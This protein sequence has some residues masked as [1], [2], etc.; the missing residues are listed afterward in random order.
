MMCGLFVT[1][2]R[3]SLPLT[4]RGARAAFE[5]AVSFEGDLIGTDDAQLLSGTIRRSP[6]LR[7]FREPLSW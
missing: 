5:A 1:N 2:L 6:S 3:N 7:A 4:F